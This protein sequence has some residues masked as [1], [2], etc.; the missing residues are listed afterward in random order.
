MK[1]D[2]TDAHYIELHKKGYTVDMVVLLWW[3]QK[4]LAIEHIVQGSK[5]IEAIYNVM[6]RKGLITK[7][8]K[9]TKIGIEILDFISKKTNKKFMKP[10]V[11]AT[12]FDEWWETFPANDKFTV[13]NKTFGPT[14][15]FKTKKDGCKLLFDK[16]VLDG[17]FTAEQII[18]ATQYD[19]NLKLERSYKT[20]S[21]QLKYLQNSHTY[22]FQKTFR[23]FVDMGTGEKPKSSSNL[24]SIDI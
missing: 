24:G 9:V 8:D 2:I 17:E 5:K 10:K 7:D 15:A 4:G 21:N 23:G 12:K 18:D 16:M 19:I 14:R 13:R 22:L 11:H 1:L 3:V 20:N 6:I